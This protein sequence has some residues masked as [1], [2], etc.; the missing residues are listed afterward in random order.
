VSTIALEGITKRFDQT[1][2]LDGVDLLLRAGEVHAL[3]GQN[4]S[5]KSTLVK[6][7]VGVYAADSGAVRL[8]EAEDPHNY[9]PSDYG[10]AVIHQNLGLSDDLTVLENFGI[11]GGFG[12]SGAAGFVSWANERK[13][14]AEYA[15]RI[16]FSAAPNE[17]LG[18]LRPADRALLAIMRALRDLDDAKG[19]SSHKLLVLDEPTTYLPV[20]EKNRL[21]QTMRTLTSRGIGVLLVSHELDYVLGCSDSVTVLRDGQVVGNGRAHDLDK[22]EIVRQMIGRS[23]ARFYPEHQAKPIGSSL[24]RVD[25]LE[26]KFLRPFSVDVKAGEIVGLT[27]L[28]GGG[29]EEFP[30]SVARELERGSEHVTLSPEA[31]E[32]GAHLTSPVAIVPA[33]R[34]AAGMWIDGTAAENVT[35]AR[36]KTF[37]RGGLLRR[38]AERREAQSVLVRYGVRPPISRKSMHQFSGGNQQKIVLARWL[39][40]GTKVFILHEPVQGIDVAANA[41]IFEF[42]AAASRAGA[43][44]VICSNE[45]DHLANLC[46][47]VI[48]LRNGRVVTELSGAELSEE[49]LAAAC[50]GGDGCMPISEY[51]GRE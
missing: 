45:W 38:A 31:R 43:A 41:E 12:R 44:M 49:N 33:E 16:G 42:I 5:G 7:L 19:A 21:A 27:G 36:L 11:T 30:Y 13:V 34:D 46:D 22:G 37:T 20:D 15:N 17:M 6:I 24:L 29:H 50:Q 48:A 1:V 23:L 2:A 47:R 18:R 4:G 8:W 25:K 14:F 10:I 9:R 3:C 39:A 35:I 32:S 51:G 26:G 28:A 40:S